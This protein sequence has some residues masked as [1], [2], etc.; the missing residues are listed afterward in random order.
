MSGKIID[1]FLTL[2]A[3]AEHEIKIKGSRFIAKGFSIES[4]LDCQNI[5]EKIR[6]EEYSATHHCYAYTIGID[7]AKFKYSD[8]GEPSG[9]AGRPIFQTITGHELKNVIII[10]I[11]YYGGTKLGTGGLIRAYSGAASE[12]LDQARI[13]ERLICDRLKFSIAFKYYDQL[14][15][16]IDAEKFKI[17]NQN[18]ADEVTMEL[19][20]RK[21]K[22]SDFESRLIEL[23]GGQVKIE[24]NG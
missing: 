8:D 21:S 7:D 17:I 18:F 1:S 20:I 22:T 11:R 14:M 23:T 5:L 10:V 15:R 4:E 16:I 19:K 3:P 13:V 12:M 6:K 2:A 24:K 9:T